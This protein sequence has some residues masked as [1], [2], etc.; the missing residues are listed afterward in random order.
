MQMA[1]HLVPFSIL[2]AAP[3]SSISSKTKWVIFAALEKRLL[4]TSLRYNYSYLPSSIPFHRCR[5]RSILLVW[6]AASDSVCYD[7]PTAQPNEF[8]IFKVKRSK[9][10]HQRTNLSI[11]MINSAKIWYACILHWR[12]S[13]LVQTVS[14]ILICGFYLFGLKFFINAFSLFIFHRQTRSLSRTREKGTRE[15]EV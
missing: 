8:T 15:K 11:G 2:S 5:Y 12:I 4:I 9:N 7:I 6:K 14:L 13:M 1:A 10:K 3:L